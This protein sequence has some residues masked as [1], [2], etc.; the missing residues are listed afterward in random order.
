M[1]LWK[2]HPAGDALPGTPSHIP[3]KAEAAPV[4]VEP[5]PRARPAVTS[6]HAVLTREVIVRGDISG[7]DALFLDGLVE[8]SVTIPNERV[9]IGPN[10]RL[11]AP[12]GLTTPC[13]TAREVVILGQVKGSVF[14]EEKVEIR[15]KGSVSGDISTLRIS[16]E[17][18][19]IFRGGI[20]IR[21]PKQAA[22][23]QV[24]EEVHLAGT[25]V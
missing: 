19:A 13:I 3:P 16:I 20:D 15:A 12:A 17:D 25:A 24:H 14:A 8:G 2:Q 1:P 21:K 4:P 22:E 6:D 11:H 5:V 10:G 7:T 9:T 23:M 18:G